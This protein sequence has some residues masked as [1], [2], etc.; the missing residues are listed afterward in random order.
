MNLKEVKTIFKPCY[1]PF[2]LPKSQM[3]IRQMVIL[4]MATHSMDPL[5]ISQLGTVPRQTD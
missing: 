1:R 2:I 4:Q 3:A 5:T